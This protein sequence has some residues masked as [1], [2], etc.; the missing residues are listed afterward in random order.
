MFRKSLKLS[1]AV[2]LIASHIML[3]VGDGYAAAPTVKLIVNPNKTDVYVGS[4]SVALT[5]KAS[6]SGLQFKWE[7]QGPG[8]IEGTGSAVFYNIPDEIEGES[9]RAMITVTVTDE[10]GQET[11]ETV[12]FNILASKIPEKE[13]VPEPAKPAKKGM[14]TGKKV[15]IGVGA[16]ALVGGGVAAV[17]ALTGDDDKKEPSFTGT[18]TLET[19]G[20]LNGYV[21][22]DRFTF[23]LTQSD[24]SITGTFTLS[25]NFANCCTATCS[26]PV[27]GTVVEKLTADLSWPESAVG[28]CYC[29]SLRY[30]TWIN[31]RSRRYT[32]EDDGN[33]LRSATGAEYPRQ[34]KRSLYDAG[35]GV[36]EDESFIPGGG[37]YIRQ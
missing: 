23:N 35:K 14:S 6:G 36:L 30:R 19:V 31:A 17:L 25:S 16:A 26:T 32:L 28:T 34:A 10:A 27:R 7:L 22:Y 3:L 37:D 1:I 33:I 24:S 9:A 4:E 12:T 29:G 18:F 15:A 11:T 2:V 5:A 13:E 8:K 21:T 20:Y